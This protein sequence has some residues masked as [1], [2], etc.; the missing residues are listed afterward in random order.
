MAL[1]PG[2][3]VPSTMQ[4]TTWTDLTA[5]ERDALRALAHRDRRSEGPVTG[6]DVGQELRDRGYDRLS[7]SR[8]YANLRRLE[9]KGLVASRYVD[10][11]TKSYRPT[12][13]AREL[14]RRHVR[15]A[16]ADHGLDL[17]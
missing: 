9:S 12:D 4:D 5:F 2:A 16:A 14:A 3:P 10:G 6:V 11:R 13:R 17:G 7:R 1:F 15:G 8:L